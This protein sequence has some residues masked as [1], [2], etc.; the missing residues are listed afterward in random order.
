MFLSPSTS[1]QNQKPEVPFSLMNLGMSMSSTPSV[2][3]T[4]TSVS[5]SSLIA[6]PT[7][8][9]T[10]SPTTFVPPNT[11]AEVKTFL[12][13]LSTSLISTSGMNIQQLS[14]SNPVLISILNHYSKIN[15]NLNTT[16]PFYTVATSIG[17]NGNLEFD[18]NSLPSDGDGI[19]AMIP[20]ESGNS[21]D[22]SSGSDIVTVTRGVLTNGNKTNQSNQ[23]TVDNKK[24]LNYGDSFLVGNY[25]YT[26]GASGSPVIMTVQTLPPESK[27]TKDTNSSSGWSMVTI[28]GIIVVVGAIIGGG[29][30]YYTT[31]K[32]SGQNTEL[33]EASTTSSAST[34]STASSTSSASSASS[35]SSSSSLKTPKS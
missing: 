28:I 8:P 7:T 26:Y 15:P 10:P 23:I 32:S 27:A 13:G 35:D 4:E 24:W 18:T 3:N 30:Y 1:N 20:L 21:I 31:T 33:S 19:N 16:L 9:T 34:A 6:T 14:A 12:S 22:I 2:T 5:L 17:S 11:A 29:Y 25:S